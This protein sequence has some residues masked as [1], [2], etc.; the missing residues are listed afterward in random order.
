ME[1]AVLPL[2]VV[3]G[4]AIISILINT[5]GYK[6]ILILFGVIVIIGVGFWISLIFSFKNT[7]NVVRNRNN[8]PPPPPPT[9]AQYF[10]GAQELNGGKKRMFGKKRK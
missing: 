5:I 1:A 8:N 3:I 9:G 10:P 4:G 7:V 6:G 2:G